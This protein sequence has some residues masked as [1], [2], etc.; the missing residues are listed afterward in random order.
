LRG[1]KGGEKKMKLD[2]KTVANTLAVL[3][4]VFFL[5][6][7]LLV[8]VLPDLYKSIAQSWMHG[9]DLSLIWKPRTGNFLTGLVSFTLVSW[10]SGWV[11]AVLY[12]KMIKR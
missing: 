9:I 7:Y 10:I 1:L 4:A 12:N 8:L 3:G 5:G 6:C 11:F 2:Q